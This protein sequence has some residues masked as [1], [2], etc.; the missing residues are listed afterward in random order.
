MRDSNSD[1]SEYSA[2]GAKS[3]NE[4]IIDG[5]TISINSYDDALHRNNDVTH[6]N[7]EVLK[8]M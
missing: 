7:G 4:I 8:E 6:K 2:K 3:A 5:G 1:K